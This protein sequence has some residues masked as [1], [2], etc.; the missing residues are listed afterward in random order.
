[1]RSGLEYMLNGLGTGY[2]GGSF[3]MENGS[4]NPTPVAEFQQEV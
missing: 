1:M 2:L 3:F 4:I